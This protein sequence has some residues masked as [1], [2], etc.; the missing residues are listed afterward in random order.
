MDYPALLAIATAP[1]DAVIVELRSTISGW[2]K[3]SVA[4]TSTSATGKES[5]IETQQ[6]SRNSTCSQCSS[7]SDCAKHSKRAPTV[8]L[9]NSMKTKSQKSNQ[10]IAI[11][12]FEKDRERPFTP[13]CS[14]FK[15]SGE[16][17]LHF[18]ILHSTKGEDNWKTVDIGNSW[19]PASLISE[20]P[21]QLRQHPHICAAIAMSLDAHLL[22]QRWCK[23]TA[24][25]AAELALNYVKF[26]EYCWLNNI[27][28]FS[29]WPFALWDK[30]LEKYSAGGWSLALDI[31]ERAHKAISGMSKQNLDKISRWD[32]KSITINRTEVSRLLGTNVSQIETRPIRTEIISRYPVLGFHLDQEL[33]PVREGMSYAR[34]LMLCTE[35]IKLADLP[36]PYGLQNIPAFSANNFAKKKW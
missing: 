5:L 9:Q 2:R 24:E 26:S 36:V 7:Q 16:W 32:R 34:V 1:M 23:T 15:I 13:F 10:N 28:K 17:V 3:P 35:L 14:N 8:T 4:S 12:D 29:D 22:R 30:L 19:M 20:K 25:V 31:S 18:K 6:H 33:P 27:H 21:T 11:Q